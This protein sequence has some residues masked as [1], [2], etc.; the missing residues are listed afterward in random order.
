M[1]VTDRIYFEAYTL[2]A[3]FEAIGILSNLPVDL[4]YHCS[5]HTLQYVYPTAIQ[6]AEGENLSEEEK[7]LVAVTALFHD[8]GFLVQYEPHELE[9]AKNAFQYASGSNC[10]I[11]QRNA[12]LIAKAILQTSMKRPPANTIERIIRDADVSILGYPEFIDWNTNL[13]QEAL[14]HPESKLHA[15]ALDDESWA[16]NQLKFLLN[17]RWFT[18]SG[19]RIFGERKLANIALFQQTYSNALSTF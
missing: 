6:L 16:T 15:P 13:R 19:E 4:I 12:R 8:T 10:I 9:G 17:H 3:E 5:A 18:E 11:L 7:L 14:L 2:D 1:E